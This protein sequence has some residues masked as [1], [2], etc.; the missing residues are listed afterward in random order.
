VS[1]STVIPYQLFTP[2]FV[3]IKVFDGYGRIVNTVVAEN[4]EPSVYE[5]SLEVSNLDSGVY[6]YTMAVDNAFVETKRMVVV[7]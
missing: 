7:R 3:V 6:Y 5:I 1:N 2:G 4:Q